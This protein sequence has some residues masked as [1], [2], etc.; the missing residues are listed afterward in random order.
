MAFSPIDEHYTILQTEERVEETWIPGY[1]GPI[2]KVLNAP[3]PLRIRQFGFCEGADI[4]DLI[5]GRGDPNTSVTLNTKIHGSF[6]NMHKKQVSTN[7]VE[8]TASVFKDSGGSDSHGLIPYT[9]IWEQL[10]T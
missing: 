5:S 7:D 2:K 8:M 4:A 6:N 1:T 9:I 3:T 10:H